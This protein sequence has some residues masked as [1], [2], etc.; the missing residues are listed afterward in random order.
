MNTWRAQFGVKS[1]IITSANS[2]INCRGTID[3]GADIHICT[4]NATK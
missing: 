4:P 1:V 3:P 2:M